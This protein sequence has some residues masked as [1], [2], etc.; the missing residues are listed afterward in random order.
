MLIATEA[1]LMPTHT[2]LP[3]VLDLISATGSL[4]FLWLP[5]VL[6]A[7]AVGRKQIGLKFLFVFVTAE[8]IAMA[9]A[10]YWHPEFFGIY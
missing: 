7:F 10:R 9:L 4:A 2:Y 8:A 3:S 6:V 5:L 1:H